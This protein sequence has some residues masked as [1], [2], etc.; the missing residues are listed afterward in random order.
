MK[1]FEFLIH[2]NEYK[3]KI[4]SFTEAENDQELAKVLVN[5]VEYEVALKRPVAKTP[6]IKRLPVVHSVVEGGG[7]LTSQDGAQSFSNIKAP[8]PGVIIKLSCAVGD[9]VKMGQTLLVL[10]AMKMQNELQSPKD[11]KIKKINVKENQNVV[12]GEDLIVIE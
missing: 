11:G 3:V 8:L 2:G 5:G 9:D 6:I 1:E 12:E 10:E 7:V 4:L